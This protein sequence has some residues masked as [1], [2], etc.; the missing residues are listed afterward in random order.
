MWYR[1]SMGFGTWLKSLGDNRVAV[2][3][4]A[5]EEYELKPANAPVLTASTPQEKP[6]MSFKSFVTDVESELGKAEKELAQWWGKE[7]ALN[8]VV[9]IA[10][11]TIG[12]ALET[13]FTLEGNGAGASV[14]GDAVSK[15]QQDLLAVK[16]LVAT[17]GPTP[18]VANVLKGVA[19]DVGDLATIAGIK[20]PTSLAS[21][22]IA[23][24]TAETLANTITAAVPTPPAPAAPPIVGT[25]G[26]SS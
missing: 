16:T 24:T 12:T 22:K 20:N 7:P 15:V 10:A 21:L 3:P 5:G 14:V 1:A 11:T 2:Q 23:T 17:V 8:N 13:V 6:F 4:L 18:S 19:S 26:V 9:G 25:Q